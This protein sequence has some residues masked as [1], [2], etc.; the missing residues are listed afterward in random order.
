MANPQ[1]QCTAPCSRVL[2]YSNPK[3]KNDWFT[4]GVDNAEDDALTIADFASYPAQYRASL[5][6]IFYDGFD[7]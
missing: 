5:G 1:P 3:V 2:N 4:T 6:R 7:N